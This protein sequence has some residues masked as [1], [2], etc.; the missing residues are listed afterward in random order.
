MTSPAALKLR[1]RKWTLASRPIASNVEQMAVRRQPVTFF[2]PR[3]PAGLAFTQLWTEVRNLLGL[4]ED[5]AG[6]A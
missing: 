1:S 3:S 6:Q 2:A 5:E 4:A